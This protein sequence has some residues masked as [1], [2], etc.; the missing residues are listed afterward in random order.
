MNYNIIFI[1]FWGNSSHLVFPIVGWL[2]DFIAL[3]QD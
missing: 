1:Q 2:N 3:Q